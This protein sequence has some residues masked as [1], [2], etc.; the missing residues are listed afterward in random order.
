MVAN[1]Y[2]RALADV[3]IARGETNAVSDELRD[4]AAMVA[5]HGELRE[6]LANPVIPFDRK[7]AVLDAL[8]ARRPLRETSNNFLRL[9]LANQRMHRLDRVLKSL[10][11][12]L[13]S[14]AGVLAADV[15]TA[16]P[17]SDVEREQLRNRLGSMTGKEVRLRFDIDPDLIGGVVTRLGSVIYDG[18]IKSQL[19]RM[20]EEL[21]RG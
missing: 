16:R 6:M 7:R 3:I 1:R 5:G 17:I 20:K 19:E 21:A 14:R 8:L 15:T 11:R 12:E 13:D 10:E 2:A 4:F 18:S 9:L